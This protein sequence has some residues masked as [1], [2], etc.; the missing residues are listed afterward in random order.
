V[1]F[2]VDFFPGAVKWNFVELAE[3]RG[4]FG[5]FGGTGFES[6]GGS[7]CVWMTDRFSEMMSGEWL[8]LVIAGTCVDFPSFLCFAVAGAN[9]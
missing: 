5:G 4:F 7:M 1:C 6:E 3:L 2:F 9:F 8:E